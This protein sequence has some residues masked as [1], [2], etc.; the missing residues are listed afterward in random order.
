MD[1][2]DSKPVIVVNLWDDYV[3]DAAE[4]ETVEQSTYAYVE[5]DDVSEDDQKIVLLALETRL[6][7]WAF[8][9]DQDIQTR[10]EMYDSL[11][12][13]PSLVGSEYEDFAYKRWQLFVDG[14]THVGREN[15]V[16]H[17][18]KAPLEREDW[19]VEVI[20]ES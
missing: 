7:A 12:K 15:F 4:G 17:M 5:H 19:R 8:A 18:G 1:Q 14:L 13:Y 2:S 10:V 6:Q 3:D 9:F 11:K 16:D 20:S